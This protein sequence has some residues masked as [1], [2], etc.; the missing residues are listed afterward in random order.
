MVRGLATNFWFVS[1]N[2][3]TVCFASWGA[4]PLGPS[5]WWSCRRNCIYPWL[6]LAAYLWCFSKRWRTVEIKLLVTLKALRLLI[7]FL[8]AS[9]SWI[10]ISL[11][12][13]CVSS[14]KVRFV[15]YLWRFWLILTPYLLA[16]IMLGMHANNIVYVWNEWPPNLFFLLW[17]SLADI[18]NFV[19]NF[20]LIIVLFYYPW[21]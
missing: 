4:S 8:S 18:H 5:V 6:W 17:C 20:K 15:C 3:I 12:W 9:W 16:I 1:R 21:R 19:E 14:C 7:S 10:I 11:Q 2:K 13:F